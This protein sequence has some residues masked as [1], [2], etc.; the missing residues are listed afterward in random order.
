A[1]E[2]VTSEAGVILARIVVGKVFRGSNLASQES[3]AQWGVGNQPNA[4]LAQDRQD[5]R[6]RVPGPEGVLRLQGGD[7][8]HRVGTADRVRPGL[9]ET[10]VA[11][12]SLGNQ[13]RQGADGLLDG[14]VG[15]DSVLVVQIDVVGP[16][17]PKRAL[18]RGADVGWLAVTIPGTATGV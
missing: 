9:G 14:R 11:D 3:A 4:Q 13:L 12:L 7:W 6:L 2:V 10:D 16:Q 15:V 17:P 5:L 18:K 1:L 8:M